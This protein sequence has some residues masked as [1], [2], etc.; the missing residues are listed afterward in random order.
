[1]AREVRALDL[2]IAILRGSGIGVGGAPGG[3]SL[4]SDIDETLDQ[5]L[6]GSLGESSGALVSVRREGHDSL[7]PP[8]QRTIARGDVLLKELSR[9]R[10]L[11]LRAG[12]HVWGAVA[13]PM[14]I[15]AV[16]LGIAG[17]MLPGSDGFAATHYELNTAVIL[18]LGYG[19]P[20]VVTWAAA[21]LGLARVHES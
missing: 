11:L 20:F 10:N 2:K 17:A 14:A 13:G 19:W 12:S 3:I 5:I 16:F 9:A 8:M 15:G 6:G 1:V 18:F 7:A 4:D 21:S